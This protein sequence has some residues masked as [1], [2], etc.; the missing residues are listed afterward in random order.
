MGAPMLA[1]RLLAN[2][3]WHRR[4]RCNVC[5]RATVFVCTDRS[6]ARD[7]LFCVWCRSFTRKR[8]V[9]AVLLAELGGDQRSLADVE[10]LDRDVYSASVDD[11]LWHRLGRFERFTASELSDRPLG[12]SLPLGGQSE[13]LERLTLRSASQDVVI[14][15][16]VLEHVRNADRAFAE[17]ARVLRPGGVHLFT[18]PVYLDR[19]T[20]ERVEPRVGEP[21]RVLVEPLEYHGD[22]VGTRVLAYRTFGNDLIPRLRQFG[23]ETTMQVS[24]YDQLRL[25]IVDS[26]V[27][28]SRRAATH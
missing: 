2:A 23:F 19:P 12:T 3:G 24:R 26:A 11:H 4:G 15:E 21:D 22:A 13:D 8:H 5:G 10:H 9:V 27:F 25:G 16:D 28:T 14:T 7:N 6:G 17:I 1:R 20:L 18:V